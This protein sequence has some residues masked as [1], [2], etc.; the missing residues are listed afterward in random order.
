MKKLLIAI[1]ILAVIGGIVGYKMYNKPHT[2]IASTK[3][4]ITLTATELFNDFDQDEQMANEKYLGKIVEVSGTI[5]QVNK[6]DGEIVS[7]SLETGDLLAG[8]TCLLDEVDNS[9][10]SDFSEGEDVTMRC[11]CTGKLMD[12]ELNR[13][14]EI[15]K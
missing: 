1:L 6:T 10:R 9:H 13:C 14:V 4:E 8:M 7:V 2:D 15:K 3:P 11:I 5:N 12:I